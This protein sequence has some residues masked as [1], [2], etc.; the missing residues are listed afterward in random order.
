M[1]KHKLNWSVGSLRFPKYLFEVFNDIDLY[2]EFEIEPYKEFSLAF[3]A[4]YWYL[5]YRVLKEGSI[6]LNKEEF[7][8]L[9]KETDINI[10]WLSVKDK[11]NFVL[12]CKDG[13]WA[14][15][16]DDSFTD[17]AFVVQ[18]IELYIKD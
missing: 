5:K 9:Y 14:L 18:K 10:I 11:N 7:S 16:F 8:Q 2:G 17:A 13:D 6:N 1:G 3:Q 15:T 4:E 12:E